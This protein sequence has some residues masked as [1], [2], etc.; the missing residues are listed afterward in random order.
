MSCECFIAGKIALL[1]TSGALDFQ[2][3]MNRVLY[4][5][6]DIVLDSTRRGTGQ[7]HLRCNVPAYFI[8][9]TR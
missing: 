2:S 4:L 6:V 9:S 3:M 8:D 7:S 1:L 5:L